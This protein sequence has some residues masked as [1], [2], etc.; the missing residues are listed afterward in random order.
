M[1]V[2]GYWA[3]GAALI[4]TG[5]GGGGALELLGFTENGAD[6]EI[7]KH[8][9]DILTDIFGPLTPQ[10]IQDFGEV[11]QV[12]VPL[13]AVDRTVLNK[14]MNRGDRTLNGMLNTPGRLIGAQGQ[15]MR[16]GIAAPVDVPYSF[17]NAIV[18]PSARFRMAT[19]ANPFTIS[20]FCWP[21][22]A[23]TVTTG[24]DAVLYTRSLA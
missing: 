4:Y 19:R 3:P 20:F 23:Y 18:R 2:D 8:Y 17:N 7:T 24:K 13:I 16:L 9:A 12:T 14:A 15:S 1:A 11:A 21:Y 22:A 10:E 6:V 5:T